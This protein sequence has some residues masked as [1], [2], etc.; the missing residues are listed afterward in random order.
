MKVGQW[1]WLLASHKGMKEGQT[2]SGGHYV[3]GEEEGAEEELEDHG[4]G[5][6]PQNW[7]KS[8]SRVF[9]KQ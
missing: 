4:G 2:W 8:V 1:C 7:K 9:Y 3:G 6:L 5:H